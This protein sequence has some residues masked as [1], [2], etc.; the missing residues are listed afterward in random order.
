MNGK[1][2]WYNSTKAQGVIEV[3]E[4]GTIQ[5]YFLLQS[6]IARQ[7]ELIKAGQFVKFDKADPPPKPGLLPMARAVEISEASSVDVGADRNDGGTE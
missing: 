1:I 3:R 6:R 2:V 7:P 5:K 4:S